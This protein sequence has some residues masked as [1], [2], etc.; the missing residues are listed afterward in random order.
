MHNSK[1]A[2]VDTNRSLKVVS[3][4]PKIINMKIRFEMGKTTDAFEYFLQI[5]KTLNR[6]SIKKKRVTT[7]F[8]KTTSTTA[9]CALGN[10]YK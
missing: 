10:P 3:T 4:Q 1:K 5:F 9:F 2:I 7:P 8:D 6:N